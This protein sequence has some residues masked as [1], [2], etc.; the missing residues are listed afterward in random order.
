M[1]RIKDYDK[2]KIPGG[3]QGYL[4]PEYYLKERVSS[5]VARKQDYFALGSTLFYIKYGEHL[6]KYK[7]DDE[8]IIK[9]DT[10]MELLFRKY[11]FIKRR[12]TIKQEFIGFIISLIH[13]DI[14]NRAN[15]EEIYR[16]KWL[17]R[18]KET[19]EDIV[20]TNENDAEKIIMELQK[21]DFLINKEK[22]L[23]PE[24]AKK[25]K[26]KKKNL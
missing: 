3:T 15:F 17:N 26:F 23:N 24:K 9:Y 20:Y 2:A 11:E 21:S 19:I 16:N 14:N 13:Y 8:S 4:S 12:Q 22:D 18:N 7:K 25:F 5:E 10:V 1:T 6:L